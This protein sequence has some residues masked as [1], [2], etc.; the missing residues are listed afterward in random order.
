MSTP[1]QPN[2]VFGPTA[3]SPSAQAFVSDPSMGPGYATA[4][5]NIIGNP[6]STSIKYVNPGTLPNPEAMTNVAAVVATFISNSNAGN[7]PNLA[8]EPQA[9][10]TQ[11]VP[12]GASWVLVNGSYELQQ[13]PSASGPNGVTPEAPSPAPSSNQTLG[14]T[15][16]EQYLT[17]KLGV[18]G[19][20]Q[21]S[22]AISNVTS[23]TSSFAGI[24]AAQ[25]AV[26]RFQ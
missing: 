9:G 19:A 5:L 13:T 23:I 16:T 26:F 24:P 7:C 15:G 2:T 21:G 17:L 12:N 8:P 1:L 4:G 3:T 14:E 22:N 25:I 18:D 20:Q 11:T 6:N 10:W